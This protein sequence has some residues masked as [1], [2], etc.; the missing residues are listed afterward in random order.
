MS[1][2]RSPDGQAV[3]LGGLTDL[4]GYHLRMAQVAMYRD[5]A[6]HLAEMNLTQKQAATMQLIA[7]NEGICQIDIGATLGT[8]RSTMLALVDR[9][10]RRGLLTRRQSRAVGRRQ[11]LYL[12]PKGEAT[13]ARANTLIRQHER[14]FTERFSAAE[15]AT[16]FDAL[17]RIHL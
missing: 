15:L 4:L 16:L 5:F 10:Q 6:A 9:L 8:D 1:L 17:K 2:S 7:A 3:S 14:K 11:E 13:L 12:T